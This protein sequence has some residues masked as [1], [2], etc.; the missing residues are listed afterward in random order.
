MAGVDGERNTLAELGKG[1]GKQA[2][3]YVM[4]VVKPETLL[5]WHRRLIA[6]E[7]DGSQHRPYPGRPR[8][9]QDIED[10]VVQFA[11]ENRMWR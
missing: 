8:G 10:F 7:F 9:H 6:K 4:S 11:K 5:A 3:A 1:L 2:L